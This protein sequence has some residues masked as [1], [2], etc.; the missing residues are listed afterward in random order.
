M[1]KEVRG[2]R[3]Y[4]GEIAPAL[5]ITPQKCSYRF[6]KLEPIIEETSDPAFYIMPKRMVFLVP[7][8]FSL[9]SYYFFLY[10]NINK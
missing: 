5:L 4:S 9:L 1:L 7:A 8:L 3:K 2:I 6:S 10:N